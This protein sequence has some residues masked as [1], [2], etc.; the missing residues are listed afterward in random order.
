MR[1]NISST[2]ELRGNNT[3][4]GAKSR[5]IFSNLFKKNEAIFLN[6]VFIHV[7]TSF[8]VQE[9]IFFSLLKNKMAAQWLIKVN[10]FFLN[11]LHERTAT[12]HNF[13]FKAKNK[14][15]F[16]RTCQNL[17]YYVGILRN[18]DFLQK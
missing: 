9:K 8:E 2:S 5:V 16:G 18:I 12:G 10:S 13:Q 14:K 1:M 4:L 11:D 15:D 17:M 7:Y 3:L 6:S